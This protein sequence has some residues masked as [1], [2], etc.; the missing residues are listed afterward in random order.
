MRI[1]HWRWHSTAAYPLVK[2]II[3]GLEK[4]LEIIELLAVH[5]GKKGAGKLSQNDVQF[6][7]T[8]MST[9]KEKPLASR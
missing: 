1:H 4:G 9:T 7:D 6:A 2:I 5:L 3:V 8:A